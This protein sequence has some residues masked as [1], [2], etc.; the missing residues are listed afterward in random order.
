MK[1]LMEWLF[2]QRFAP[3]L[4]LGLTDIERR[5]LDERRRLRNCGRAI[6]IVLVV[7]GLLA[8]YTRLVP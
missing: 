8:D 1:R 3:R 4:M 2:G 5:M 6:C 7:A